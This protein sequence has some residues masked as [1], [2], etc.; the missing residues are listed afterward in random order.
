[1]ILSVTLMQ[2]ALNGIKAVLRKGEIILKVLNDL[3]PP[4]VLVLFGE[5]AGDA[6]RETQLLMLA[7]LR[8]DPQL[9]RV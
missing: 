6:S 2:P 5:I 1:M 3:N 4:T 8:R 9:F 7:L